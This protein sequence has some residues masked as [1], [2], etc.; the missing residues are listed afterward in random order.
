MFKK[1]RVAW[2][3]ILIVAGSL[4]ANTQ[5][6]RYSPGPLPT[7]GDI[8]S[9]CV[10][11]YPAPRDRTHL[12]IGEEVLC[13]IDPNTWRD[14]DICTDVEGNAIALRFPFLL[15]SF[16]LEPLR[17]QQGCVLLVSHNP[18]HFWRMDHESDNVDDFARHRGDGF[19]GPVCP[20]S[21]AVRKDFPR[22]NGHFKL[23]YG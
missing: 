19:V 22:K 6:Q 9:M 3:G 8:R 15:T 18:C 13:W 21:E 20:V 23:L 11:E 16:S 7:I 17:R 10:E 1:Q 14:T 4:G 5:G 2:I 12:G